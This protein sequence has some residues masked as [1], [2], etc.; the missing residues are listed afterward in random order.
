MSTQKRDARGNPIVVG[1]MA[2]IPVIP[3][4]LTHDLPEEDVAKLKRC[5]GA[6]MRVLEIDEHGY[7]WFASRDGGRWFCLKPEEIEIVGS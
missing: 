1:E 4:W 6:L 2:R 5:E 7:L 3:H